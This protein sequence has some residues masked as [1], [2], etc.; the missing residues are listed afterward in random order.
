MSDRL[1]SRHVIIAHPRLGNG[2]L[3]SLR[4]HGRCNVGVDQICHDNIRLLT[5]TRLALRLNSHLAMINRTTTVRGIRGILNGTI[6]DLGRPG[7]ITMFVNVI[8]N[9]TL[10]TVPVSVPNVDTPIQ[11][12]LTKNPVVMNVLVKAFNPEVR[13]IA[14]AAHDTGLVLHTLKLSLCLTYLKLSTNTRFF[15]AMF[16]PRKLL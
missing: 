8:V 9:L 2:G 13:V 15:S 16:Q 14:C 3:N 10:K 1:V 5:A 12:K 11:L 4:L 7:L 6:G